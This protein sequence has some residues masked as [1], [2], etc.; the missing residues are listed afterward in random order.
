MRKFDDLWHTRQ[1]K[2]LLQQSKYLRYVFNDHLMIAVIFLFGALAY[3]YS[4]QL[5][6]ISHIL[7]WAPLLTA[8]LL[9]LGLSVGHLATLL[10]PA[11]QIF[12]LPA[13]S[14]MRRYLIHAR[15][16]SLLLPLFVLVA[17]GGILTPFVLRATALTI[18]EWL[19]TIL[20]L[21]ILKDVHL[22]L[23]LL[24]LFDFPVRQQRQLNSLFWGIATAGL[25]LSVYGWGWLFSILSLGLAILLAAQ[26]KKL[27]QPQ[28]LMWREAVAR[29]NRRQTVI[30]RFYNLFVDVPGISSSVHRRKWLDPLVQL[31]AGKS[32]NTYRFLFSRAF[33]RGSEYSNIWLRFCLVGV[34]L[35]AVIKQPVI[36]LIIVLLFL[37]LTGYQLLPLYYHF[38]HNALTTLLPVT[39]QAKQAAFIKVM[40]RVLLIEWLIDSLAIMLSLLGQWWSFIIILA[41]LALIMIFLKVYL[42]LRLKQHQKGIK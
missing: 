15:R 35:I 3:W 42:P 34:I 1:Q 37:F 9:L 14:K 11:D 26:A 30:D 41:A 33:V 20:G 12:L 38:D 18:T 19:L 25:L 31:L 24:R 6:S 39:S 13:E 8:L 16:Y 7:W 36:L 28:R 23:Q 21:L 4:Q 10:K 5:R 17:L 22:W 27:L 40:T 2:H 29:E 32:E